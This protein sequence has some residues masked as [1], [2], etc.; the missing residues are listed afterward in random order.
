[1]MRPLSLILDTNIWV[2]LY[3]PNRPNHVASY[4]MV[5]AAQEKEAQLFYSPHSMIDVFYLANSEQKSLLRKDGG[6]LTESF[7]L[8]ANEIAWGC[9]QSIYEI[10]APIPIT[11]PILSKALKMKSVH[12]DFE[13]DA[14]LAAAQIANLDFLVTNDQKLLTK[15]IVPSLSAEDMLAYLQTL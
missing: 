15:G 7:A 4:R 9:I 1:M 13:D 8:G 3:F 5:L 12:S 14:I 6:E 11:A 10:G 2:D